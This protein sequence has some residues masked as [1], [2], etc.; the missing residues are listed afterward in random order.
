MSDIQ[1]NPKILSLVDKWQGEGKFQDFVNEWHLNEHCAL[2]KWCR[3]QGDI[4]TAEGRRRFT[5]VIKNNSI[6]ARVCYYHIGFMVS[7]KV[8]LVW[9]GAVARNSCEAAKMWLED[10]TL[11]DEHLAI[12]E[13]AFNNPESGCP[14]YAEKIKSGE[15]KR[16]SLIKKLVNED[17]EIIQGIINAN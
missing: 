8:R 6:W 15:L 17:S 12:L 11:S 9:I 4:T 13:N 3:S 14:S 10:E 1:N 5:E 16:K 7:S 2:S